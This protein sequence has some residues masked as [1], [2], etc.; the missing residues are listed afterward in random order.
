MKYDL[1][2]YGCNECGALTDVLDID[3]SLPD[4][5]L[6]VSRMTHLCPACA[7]LEKLKKQED[8]DNTT[9]QKHSS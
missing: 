8:G 4:G 5:W 7:A 3:Q 6:M 9:R 2:Q 1:V